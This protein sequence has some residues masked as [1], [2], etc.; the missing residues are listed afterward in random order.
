MGRS[1]WVL[2]LM[3]LAA[4]GG[5][6]NDAAS[7][8]GTPTT[9]AN[10]TTTVEITTIP[11]STTTVTPTTVEVSAG[12][13]DSSTNASGSPSGT[14]DVNG[15]ELTLQCEGSGSP[16]VILE[17]GTGAPINAM[18]ALQDRL[19]TEHMTCAY[20]RAAVTEA[21]TFG[22]ANADLHNLLV[23][24]QVP[25]PVVLV[26]QSVGG[27]LVQLYARTYPDEVAGVISMNSGP[28]CGP[29]LAALPQLGNDSL[30]AGEQANCADSRGGGDRFDLNAS[31]VEEQAAAAPPDIPLELVIST[32]DGD[33]C[34]PS[35]NRPDP[36]ASQEQCHAAYAI[37]EQIA[38]DIVS[39]WT[40][41]NFSE[42]DAPHEIY[43]T[44]LDAISELVENV[45][46]RT[47]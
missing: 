13:S 18:S 37:H 11:A 38:R 24:A 33:W 20:E 31:Y 43:S 23:A 7:S 42:I 30:L 1:A 26:G 46:A 36:F 17:G 45:I 12:S 39:Q 47:D 32:V 28:P 6:A 4:C 16:T 27:D 10:G 2:G 44:Q 25:G 40:K 5:T 14:Y 19:A 29:W 3:A 21:R 35:A 41:G 8:A 9:R 34:P 15:H 22:D